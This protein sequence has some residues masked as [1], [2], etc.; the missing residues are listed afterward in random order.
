MLNNDFV[1]LRVVN[2]GIF[3][4]VDSAVICFNL[5]LNSHLSF[6]LM[7]SCFKESSL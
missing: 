7:Q 4:Q 1:A 2:I 6:R 3:R 5:C